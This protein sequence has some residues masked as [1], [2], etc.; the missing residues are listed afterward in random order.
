MAPEPHDFLRPLHQHS[1][2]L[3]SCPRSLSVWWKC[4]SISARSVSLAN[5]NSCFVN[6]LLNY[7]SEICRT[8]GNQRTHV[9]RGSFHF[10]TPSIRYLTYRSA[11][12]STNNTFESVR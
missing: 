4:N 7:T 9:A 6:F 3:I 11:K 2:T 10:L 8:T 1:N 5:Q 12:G